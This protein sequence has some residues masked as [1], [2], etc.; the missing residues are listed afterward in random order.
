MSMGLCGANCEYR[1]CFGYCVLSACRYP[2][3]RGWVKVDNKTTPL[4]NKTKTI[5]CP[6][7][8]QRITVD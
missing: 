7:C 6:C 2:D 3:R 8:G 4:S 5:I 1:S